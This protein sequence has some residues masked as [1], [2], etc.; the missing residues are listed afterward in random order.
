[1]NYE[2]KERELNL[3]AL[4]FCVARKWK[5][6]LVVA[7][8][9]ALALGGYRGWKGL[10]SVKDPQKLEEHNAAYEAAYAKY[11]GQLHALNTKLSQ[12][13]EDIRNHGKYMDESVLMRI[14]YRNAW[15]A[16]V[17]LYIQTQENTPVSGAGEGYTRADVI[18]DAYRN[19]VVSNRVLE[20]AAKVVDIAP[21]Y[22]RELISTPLPM[23]HEYQDGPL[24]TVLIR[25]DNAQSAKEIM[26]AL[27]ACLNAVQTEIA[28]AMG[29]HTLSTVNTG[30]T[31][32]VDEELADL[33]EDAADRL[34]EYADYLEEYRAD[35]G[36]LSAP[37]MT[38]M[39]VGSV[40]KGA[41]KYAVV[42]FLVGAFLVAGVA[43]IGFVVGDKV[44]SADELKSRFGLT[45]LGKI[46]LKNKKCCIDRLLDRM[47]DRGK[48]EEQGAMTVA[49]ANVAN[50]CPKQGVLLVAGT[51]GDAGM[52]KMVAA[53]TQALPGRTVIS[54]GTL[55][56]SL[57]A[58]EALPRCDAVVLVER[59][60]YSRYSQVSAQLEIIKGM[61]KQLLGCVVLEK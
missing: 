38:A 23:Y 60:G 24:V 13:E 28:E 51:A 19:M 26:D 39:S 4:C 27:L 1:M 18:A 37:A 5:E 45:L 3:K 59:C 17:D 8:V 43:C 34:V 54:G 31:A 15:T 33:Q 57:T 61:D 49:S 46:S 44:Y 7:L 40:V 14:D 35:L 52:E 30:V 16:S 50:H 41:V 2:N 20:E 10:S 11:E 48:T 56:E 12:V 9:L 58:I 36:L 25:S 22:L 53:L 55:L 29:E 32:R 6:M 42:G 47:E 21:Q